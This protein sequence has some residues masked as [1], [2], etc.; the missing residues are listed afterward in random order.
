ML[1]SLLTLLLVTALQVEMLAMAHGWFL[2]MPHHGTPRASLSLRPTL[3]TGD[4]SFLLT[5]AAGKR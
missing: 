2:N 3:D 1:E 4:I 5:F